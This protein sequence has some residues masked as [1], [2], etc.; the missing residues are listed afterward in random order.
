MTF[1]RDVVLNN[2]VGSKLKRNLTQE[3]VLVL[4]LKLT[5]GF[6]LVDNN[7]KFEYKQKIPQN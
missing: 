4:Y 5:A 7:A 1:H 6:S 2:V 3:I